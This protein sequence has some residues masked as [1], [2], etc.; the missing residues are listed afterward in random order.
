MAAAK[1]DQAA[2]QGAQL[3]EGDKVPGRLANKC[4]DESSEKEE[5]GKA[6]R[7]DNLWR[8]LRTIGERSPPEQANKRKKMDSTPESGKPLFQFGSSIDD[9][10]QP[11]PNLNGGKL[12]IECARL[13]KENAKLIVENESPI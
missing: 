3:S 13:R 8:K 1:G 4:A 6:A 12:R 7:I 10:Y 9:R 11:T 2:N 5:M